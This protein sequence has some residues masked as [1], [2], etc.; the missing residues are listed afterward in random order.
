MAVGH[1]KDVVGLPDE[2]GREGLT[3]EGGQVN[4]QFLK[5][6][7][8]VF[9]GR[10]PLAGAQ[11]GRHDPIAAF[12][13]MPEDAFSHRAAADISGADKQDGLHVRVKGGEH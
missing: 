5:R 13:N 1:P 8:G 2:V 3:A 11:A 7:H 12:G 6:P 9:A 4:P 10:L